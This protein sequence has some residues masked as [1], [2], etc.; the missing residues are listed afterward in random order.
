[1]NY[2]F[3]KKQCVNSIKKEKYMRL[4]FFITAF[5]TL[6]ISNCQQKFLFIDLPPFDSLID[7]LNDSHISKTNAERRKFNP[8]FKIRNYLAEDDIGCNKLIF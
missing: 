2:V 4:A 5:S 8:K 6:I 7:K 1:M 3:D